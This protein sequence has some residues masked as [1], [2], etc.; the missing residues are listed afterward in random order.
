MTP[1]EPGG[2][3]GGAG[4]V[5]T[6]L[7]QHLSALVPGWDFTLLTTSSSDNEL[8]HLDAPNVS[9]RCVVRRGSRMSL[10]RRVADGL[11][12]PALR[13]RL[14]RVYWRQHTARR[15]ER[16]TTE[17]Q[18]DLLLC[19]FTVPY[20][21]RSG[22]PCVCIVY[23]LQHLTYPDFF[24]EEQ[25]LNRQ[26]HIVEACARSHRV[27]CISEFVRRTLLANVAVA[28]D[29]AVSVP[30]G[31]LQDLTSPDATVLDK[32][33]VTAGQFLLYPANF[34]PHKNHR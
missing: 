9:R 18:P 33:G 4:L 6:S 16:S 14:K 5:A 10:A 2:Q 22:V 12:P 1:L 13:V 28:P 29:L 30:L 27:V 17:L 20:F 19:P 11:L 7:V 34:W 31:L 8:A 21:W 15:Y 26:R 24:T 25:R 23:D 3:N 32:L